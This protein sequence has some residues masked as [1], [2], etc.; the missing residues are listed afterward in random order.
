MRLKEALGV[1]QPVDEEWLEKAQRR[2]DRLTKPVGSLGRLEE[3]ARRYSAIRE[4]ERP[5]IA[6]KA[7][8]VFAGDHGVA[9]EGVSAYPALVTA[10]MVGNFLSG[11]AG[12]NVLA[13]HVGAEVR[14]V[15]MGVA[16]E[17]SPS[18]PLFHRKMGLG[19]GNMAEG[20]AMGLDEAHKAIE[21][22]IRLA[23]EAKEESFDLL[24][25]GDMGIGNTTAASAITSAITGEPVER[26]TGRGTG[27]S[28]EALKKKIEIIR[29]ALKV[30][31]PD[32]R[33]PLDVLA[34]VGG[35]EIAGM[36]G[37][38]LGCAACRI[39]LVLDG[40]I[41]TAGALIARELSP[42]V[43]EYL[44]ASHCSQE[45]G[46]RVLLRRMGLVPLLDLRLR[47][48]EGTGACLGMSLIEAGV[49]IQSEMA[50]FEEA[51]VSQ[52]ED[53]ALCRD[54]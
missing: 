45:P 37:F 49:K 48:G 34:K 3:L 23:L 39:P 19:T 12:I 42:D 25:M 47:L 18:L 10:Q 11:G 24:G 4:E 7:V 50:T 43:E 53:I 29:R 13:R 14:V 30:N 1:I 41:C 32:P 22:G 17:F 21:T 27:I 9:K 8:Y 2:L 51:G 33:D 31:Q 46:H 5:R 52:K 15:D 54:S 40:F 35:F 38:A 44:F 6:K 36:A 20:P 26:V 28:G 16:F